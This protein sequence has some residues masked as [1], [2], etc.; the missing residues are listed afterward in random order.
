MKTI[1]GGSGRAGVLGLL[2]LLIPATTGAQSGSEP[3][4]YTLIH[5]ASLT[6]DCPI[7]GRPA[8]VLPLRGGF[9]LRR[10]DENPLFTAYAVENV[11]WESGYEGG[12]RY[13]LRG[14]GEYVI[15]GEVAI[16][17]QLTL[18]LTMDDGQEIKDV[19]MSSE[20]TP[21]ERL[22]PMVLVAAKQ[23]NGTPFQR[24]DVSLAAAPLHGLW[25]STAHGMTSGSTPP[26]F[27]YYKASDL[28]TGDGRRVRSNADLTRHLGLMPVA[29]DI[30]L[31][32]VAVA[33]GGDLMF[34][35]TEAAFSESL[36]PLGAGDLLSE[37]GKIVRRN[38]DLLA[39]FGPMPPIPEVGLDAVQAVSSTE[40]L[41]SLATPIFSEKLGRTL[42]RGD[43]L[44]SFG[45]VVKSA[46]QL[47]ARFQPVLEN[48]GPK[49]DE[50]GLDAIYLWPSGEAW[51]STEQ[52]FQDRTL[53][54][55]RGGD[56]LSERGY[57]VWQNLDLVAPF[58]PLE[59]LADFGLDALEIITDA[60]PVASAPTITDF[61]VN[62]ESGT[63]WLQWMGEGRFFQ[64]LGAPSANAAFQPI[65]PIQTETW[66]EH[67][68]WWPTH[69]SYFFKVRQW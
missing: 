41:F 53:G 16:T 21:V 7:C 8:I 1:M 19:E 9:D 15:G 61:T 54:P 14:R 26:P 47:L 58:S 62:R 63:V 64:V 17:Q 6:D 3:W 32:G 68:A 34:S 67:Q 5:G 4:R 49:L 69:P 2:G 22:W 46:S 13:R 30:G 28:L 10:K 51:F 36:G 66:I 39:P 56:L 37:R 27:E 23:T 59:D 44:S 43:L 25:F 45:T 29:L 38:A 60:L 31:D 11:E 55:V 20:P 52:G 50:L 35:S 57:V 24:L 48:G 12:P 42:G 40:L 18:K 65:S 33:P